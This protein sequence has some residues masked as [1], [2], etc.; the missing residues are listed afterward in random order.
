MKLV[1]WP[2]M[3]GAVGCY[4]W[5][6]DEGTGRGCSPSRLLLA[7]PNVTAYQSPYCFIMVRC[8]AVFRCPLKGSMI[9][10]IMIMCEGG[11]YIGTVVIVGLTVGYK[12][13]M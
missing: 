12:M 1:H 4:I 13:T 10:I 11:P 7:V 3:G 9:I 2:L 6:S 8:S 5:Y